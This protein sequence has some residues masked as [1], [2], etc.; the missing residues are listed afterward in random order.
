M[1]LDVKLNVE[2]A[3]GVREEPLFRDTASLRSLNCSRVFLLILNI[4]LFAQQVYTRMSFYTL[5]QT[6]I[7][8]LPIFLTCTAA[9]TAAEV[10]P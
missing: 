4:S 2:R 6:M 7:T 9:V 8:V 10:P 3:T 5:R 1:V